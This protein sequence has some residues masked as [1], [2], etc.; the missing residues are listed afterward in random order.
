M[1]ALTTI[2]LFLCIS[3]AA[4]DETTFFNFGDGTTGMKTTFGNTTFFEYE[5]ETGYKY[6]GKNVT[7]Y[8]F[9]ARVKKGSA[10]KWI[11]IFSRE[12]KKEPKKRERPIEETLIW[13]VTKGDSL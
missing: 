10:I 7:Y 2:L 9:D 4:Q 6:V 5:G 13:E 12:E 11:A 1:K 3:I 8:Y